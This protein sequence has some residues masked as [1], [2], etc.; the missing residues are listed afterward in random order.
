VVSSYYDSTF[1]RTCSVQSAL[2]RAC[3]V[4]F[5]VHAQLVNCMPGR[6][7]TVIRRDPATSAIGCGYLMPMHLSAF[8]ALRR[9]PRG[10][11]RG[12]ALCST[13][14]THSHQTHTVQQI[15]SRALPMHLSGQRSLR[16][17]NVPARTSAVA[18]TQYITH[19]VQ[20]IAP[21]ALGVATIRC[22]HSA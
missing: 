10:Q 20:Q 3:R 22:D 9:Y 13:S 16:T 6:I 19:A 18:C 17:Q 7:R 4:V 5:L 14:N 12:R 2:Q 1:T 21:R 8:C 15:A 11:P